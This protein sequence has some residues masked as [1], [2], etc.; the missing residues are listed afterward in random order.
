MAV[1]LRGIATGTHTSNQATITLNKP[2]LSQ[3][4]DYLVAFL[5]CQSSISSSD[6]TPPS[7][8]TKIGPSFTASSSTQRVTSMFAKF[9]GSSEPSTYDFGS[10]D[11]VTRLLGVIHAYSGVDTTTPVA[12]SSGFTGTSTGA[13]TINIPAFASS[14]NLFTI[15]MSAGQYT[16]P[17]SYALTSNTSGLTL[18]SSVYRASGATQN[19]PSEDTSVSRSAMRVWDGIAVSGG[20][21]AHGITTTGSFAQMCAALI[22]LNAATG[23]GAQPT[24]TPTIIGHTTVRSSG[25]TSPYTVDPA[26]N[27]VNG[28]VATDD[29]ILAV[30]TSDGNMASTKQPTPPAGWTNIVPLQAPGTGSYTFG[31]WAH[32]RVAGDTTYSWT[33]STTETNNTNHRLI[34]V[35]GADDIAHWI[36]GAI[37]KRA[38]T[39]ET[40][41]TTAQ[42]VTTTTA[43]TLGLL[44]ASERTTAVESDAQ[45]T[46]DNFTK[47]WFE[48][49]VDHTLFV[50]TKDMATAGATGSV[51][52]TYPNAQ[53]QNGIA[54][55]LG[56]PGT[57]AVPGPSG[58]SI[59]VSNGSSLV[60]AKFKLSNGA[61][62]LVTPGAYKVVRPGYS[63]VTQMLAQTTFYCAHRGGSRDFP[64]M[65]M[66]AYGQSAL[67]GYPALELSLARTSDGVW[68]GLHD[69]SLDRTSFNT[70]GGSGTTYIPSS[71]TWAQVQ[72]Y[73]ILGAMA[74][75]NTTQ[76]N[77]PYMRWEEIIAMYYSSHVIFV[78]PKVA[79]GYR[80]ELLN[81][82]DAL[83]NSTT[84]F[85]GKYYGVSGGA[86]DASGWNFDCHQRGYK[87][88]G[89][90]Y[91]S[92]SA[93]FATYAPRWD[94]VG[95]DYNASQTAWN[96][97]AAAA[98]AKPIMGH[99]CPT[100]AAVSTAISKG[101]NGVMVSGV[102]SALP[103]VIT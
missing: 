8:W 34:F 86:S 18:E 72:S 1:A 45:V 49:N 93:N 5:H 24:V 98:P 7:G 11:T 67:L 47:Q 54:L 89:Y 94:I 2:S 23:G 27:L 101:A 20:I 63:S 38:V 96:D 53:A 13:Q 73:S 79:I 80:T 55:I 29:W 91:E 21:S 4:G 83:P 70:G 40:T 69:A 59:K 99:I 37:A 71:M 81:M 50:A 6:W 43:H 85:V 60:D 88:W 32:K 57:T 87:T 68:F 25:S 17:N 12:A 82:M 36:T 14:A 9:A 26:V 90:F 39:G 103:P 100:V 74:A 102:K 97:L 64:E 28:P 75:N 48:N 35:R 52:V 66:Y 78:D 84:K 16:S 15:E 65:S 51:T 31:V 61:G 76:P 19:P 62:G 42:G 77:R 3:A 22:S 30:F 56:I 33:Q 46:C 58:L 92:D 95:M 44:L 41:T 10:P